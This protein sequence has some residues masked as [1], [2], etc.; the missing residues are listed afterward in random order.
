MAQMSISITDKLAEFV[1]DKVDAG[2][3]NNASE[4][5]REA[6]RRM[7]DEERR[8][9][10]LARPTVE[11]VLADLTAEQIEGIRAR[12]RAGVLEIEKGAFATY[13]GG[14]DLR[15]LAEGVQARGRRRLAAN[16]P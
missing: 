16:Q 6:L 10:R 3:Y 9:A 4:V 1:R 8:T 5:V 11:N 7:E 2:R 14:E 12:V 13:E 15:R